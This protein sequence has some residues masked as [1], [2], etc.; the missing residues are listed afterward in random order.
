VVEARRRGVAP[1]A[2][3]IDESG[4]A[5]LKKIYNSKYVQVT[6]KDLAPRLIDL[7]K[8]ILTVQ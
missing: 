8:L 7:V 2:V 6:P 5:Y 1:F 4:G 3:S